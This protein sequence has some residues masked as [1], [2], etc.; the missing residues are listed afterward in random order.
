MPLVDIHDR[1]LKNVNMEM[2]R[3]LMLVHVLEKA[4]IRKHA[5]R[6]DPVR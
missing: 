6:R 3:S 1:A 2:Y 4:A 5:H